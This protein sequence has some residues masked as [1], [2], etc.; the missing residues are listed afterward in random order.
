MTHPIVLQESEIRTPTYVEFDIGC[1]FH[2]KK[3]KFWQLQYC[4]ICTLFEHQFLTY[5]I[6]TGNCLHFCTTSKSLILFTVPRESKG[7]FVQSQHIW[8][9]SF[10]TLGPLI[11]TSPSVPKVGSYIL[12]STWE[13]TS[14]FNQF[15][16]G[17][18]MAHI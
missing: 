6:E 15:F 7:R 10:R 8:T 11:C 18:L 5:D 4:R 17:S 1:A 14:L 9:G 12:T 13:R 16:H 3:I 2:I